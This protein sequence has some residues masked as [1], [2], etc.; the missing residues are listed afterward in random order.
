MSTGKV[1]WTRRHPAG[2]WLLDSGI[3]CGP[4]T[5]SLRDASVYGCFRQ[6]A[7]QGNNPLDRTLGGSGGFLTKVAANGTR[8]SSWPRA[9]DNGEAIHCFR[10]GLQYLSCGG[11]Q[12]PRNKRTPNAVICSRADLI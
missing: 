5:H 4:T 3:S 10:H 7:V 8:T 1:S 9:L 11:N 6:Y 12:P 2:F